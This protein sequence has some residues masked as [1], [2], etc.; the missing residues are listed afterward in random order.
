MLIDLHLHIRAGQSISLIN[1]GQIFR[2]LQKPVTASVLRGTVNIASR[3]YEMLRQHPEQA[4]RVIADT[5]PMLREAER[6]GLM[7]RIRQLLRWA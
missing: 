7:T 6:T 5:A 1:H 3:R 2:L 4:Q